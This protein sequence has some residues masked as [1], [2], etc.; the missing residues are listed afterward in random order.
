MREPVRCLS[1]ARRCPG[2]HGAHCRGSRP[3]RWWT[4]AAT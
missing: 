2:L 1:G 3:T 4:R